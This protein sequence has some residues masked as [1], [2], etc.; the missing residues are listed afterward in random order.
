MTYKGVNDRYGHPVGDAVLSRIAERAESMLRSTDTLARIGG[1]EIA[2]I[3]PGAHGE[4][5]R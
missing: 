5:A 3:T 4:S 2:V 1:G